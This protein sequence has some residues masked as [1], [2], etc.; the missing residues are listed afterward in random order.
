VNIEAEYGTYRYHMKKS[1][2]WASKAQKRVTPEVAEADMRMSEYHYILA[3]EA[4]KKE[5][6][7]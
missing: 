5:E 3:T 4:R 7:N 6:E 1:V 2:E